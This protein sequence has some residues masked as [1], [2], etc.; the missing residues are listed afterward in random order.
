M[1][2]DS[3]VDSVCAGLT[4]YAIGGQARTFKLREHAANVSSLIMSLPFPSVEMMK[5][6]SRQGYHAGRQRSL[7]DFPSREVYRISQ[8]STDEM[9]AM[10]CNG[11]VA[12]N[13]L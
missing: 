4:L 13:T 11:D 2:G 12:C 10:E 8:A 7:A 3:M 9:H 1:V 5:G 6:W